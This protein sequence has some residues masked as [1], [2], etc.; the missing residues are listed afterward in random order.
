MLNAARATVFFSCHATSGC[1]LRA[2]SPSIVE[3]LGHPAED[4]LRPRDLWRS[5]LHPDDAARVEA[6]LTGLL[7]GGPAQCEYRLRHAD[8]SYR[9]VHDE[10]QLVPGMGGEPA[11]VL[12]RWLIDG[13]EADLPALSL[14]HISEGVFWIDADARI[15]HVNRA[16]CAMLGYTHA[17]L[18]AL[19]IHDID[20][21]MT[22]EQW[23]AHWNAHRGA[24]A[25][26]REAQHRCKDA[27]LVPVELSIN[28]LEL[29]GREFHI[30]LSRDIT[31]RRR[32]GEQLRQTE[33]QLHH[34]QR[35]EAVGILAGGV[36][37][38][39]NN[40]LT[41][42]MGFGQLLERRLSDG[43]PARGN[44][45]EIL[46]AADRAAGL[47][48]QLLAF[49]RQQV[50]EPK[51]LDL[52]GVILNLDKMLRRLIGEDVDLVTAAGDGLGR[53]KADP[54]Q[55]EQVLMNL[56]VNARDAMPEGGRLTIET[57]NV[58]L[59]EA[60][61]RARLEVR[62][63]PYVLL[64]VSDTGCGMPPEIKARIFEPFFTTKERGGGTGLGLSTVHGIVKQS[65]GHIEVYSEVG[66]GT[67]FKIY[68]PRVTEVVQ[69]PKIAR[70]DE[71]NVIG[72]GTILLVED[73]DTIRL[74]MRQTLELCG[75]T[76]LEASDGS[77]AI[78]LVEAPDCHVDLLL[79][80]VV[81]P[82]MSGPDLAERIARTRPELPV[83]FMS[84]YTDRALV[85]HGLRRPG[86]AFLQ[87]P[88]T[89][90]LLARK[91]QAMLGSEHDR[92]A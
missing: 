65:D 84:G 12:G 80:D 85:H 56:A 67:T 41:A 89:P 83:L 81:M 68:L 42:I 91:V 15:V 26:I 18:T 24:A 1:P 23:R 55:L 60:Y 72:G 11:S 28:H 25:R 71:G 75:Y 21:S 5:S 8:G 16:A 77:A 53:V 51:V 3:A 46:R 59:D 9:R 22:A 70:S 62:P 38:D 57:G 74:V 61:A 31:E 87:K 58:E 92:A 66:Q 40:L 44:V 2:V 82:L 27:S 49:S 13:Q 19:C 6:W 37:H 63:G 88:F 48:R 52:N 10:R 35:L 69:E 47:T 86:T 4:Y 79:T 32:A 39:F 64:A 34:S 43:D 54:G 33:A 30:T 20:P 29:D 73:D 50:L 7:S 14:D 36:A 78:G 45:R 76:V 90:D 17:E